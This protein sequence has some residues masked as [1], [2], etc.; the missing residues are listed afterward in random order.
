MILG[1]PWSIAMLIAIGLG[2]CSVK[3]RVDLFNNT[4][5]LVTLLTDDKNI[6]VGS[7][8]FKEF[9]YPGEAQKWM[10]KLSTAGCEYTYQVPRALDHYPWT[11]GS[12]GPLKAQVE[13]DLS[14]YLLPPS[15]T[16]AAP[17]A[18]FDSLQQD[19]FPLHPVS[20]SCR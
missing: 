9:N 16:E 7:G 13:R 6:V 11:P 19:G 3:L 8:L 2:G 5:A 4:G 17:V 18:G 10:L 14:I 15:A 12:N 20:K 1:K